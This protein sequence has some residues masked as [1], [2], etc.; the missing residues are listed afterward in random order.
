MDSKSPEEVS[1][2][3]EKDLAKLSSDRKDDT[4]PKINLRNEIKTAEK[5]TTEE[6]GGLRLGIVKSIPGRTRAIIEEEDDELAT[7][8]F[9]AKLEKS[10]SCLDPKLQQKSPVHF[11]NSLPPGLT[12]NRYS[13][14]TY[15]NE[16]FSQAVS[17]NNE[18][19]M[20]PKAGSY[21][22]HDDEHN[23][24][25][26]NAHLLPKPRTTRAL[27]LSTNSEEFRK[28][29]LLPM[30]EHEGH[31][32]P[33]PEKKKPIIIE[34]SHH[35]YTGKLKFFDEGKSY[36]FIVMDDDGSD[37]FVHYD[38]L[39]KANINKDALKSAKLGNSIRL[40]FSCLEYL[41][42]YNRSRKATDIQVIN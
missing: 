30:P 33:T 26:L 34:E 39:H 31:Q 1:S 36:G 19:K 15:G 10:K 35:R 23:H 21:C 7:P 38:D 41:G 32:N 17:G 3:V 24:L 27:S 11:I 22:Q 16:D 20:R 42:K 13:T 4:L 8:D 29:P 9:I 28:N 37:I 12:P 6:S 5:P 14:K 40:S 18:F 2:L 25:G